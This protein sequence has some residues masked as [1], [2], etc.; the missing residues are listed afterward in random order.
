MRSYHALGRIAGRP[1]R[2]SAI[3]VAVRGGRIAAETARGRQGLT[4]TIK[5]RLSSRGLIAVAS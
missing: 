1:A 2:R 5:G 4:L 3:S